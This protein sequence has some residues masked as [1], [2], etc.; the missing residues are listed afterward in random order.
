MRP[1][2][3]IVTAAAVLV[4]AGPG[5]A[6]IVGGFAHRP[7]V[8]FHVRTG[9]YNSFT[10]V[11]GPYRFGF[12]PIYGPVP[13]WYY[14][15]PG[16][17]LVPN[18]YFV[19]PAP[20]TPVVIQNIIQAPGVAAAAPGPQGLVPPELAGPPAVKPAPA[21]RAARP[22]PPPRPVAPDLPRVAPGPAPAAGG[23]AGADRLAEAG[24]KAFAAGEYG[25]ALE[26]FRRAAE[27]TPHEPSAHYLVSQAQFA[28]GKYREAVAA[29]AAGI[30]VRADWPD[31]R[32]VSRDLYWKTPEAFD[33]HLK[34]LRQAVAAF[35]DDPELLFLLGHQL[36][37]DG[38]HDEARPLFQKAATVGKERTPA[39]AFLAK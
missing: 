35:P 17:P 25:R 14:G 6:Q 9:P 31:A 21:P 33:E 15:W 32:F 3:A 20:P 30:A 29:I 16:I 23:Q 26:L 34:A 18:P 37:F 7:S 22:A 39:G 11:G 27:L 13:S 24:R 19:Q 28:L 36:W 2:P 10:Y 5:H 1:S 38:R 12:G 4:A 8:G